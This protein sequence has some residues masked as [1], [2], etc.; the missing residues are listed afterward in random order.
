MRAFTFGAMLA[1]CAGFAELIAAQ[2]V[3]PPSAATASPTPS[4]SSP[5]KFIELNDPTGISAASNTGD[6][7]KLG[8]I[9]STSS[10]GPDVIAK[11]LRQRSLYQLDLS[12]ETVKTCADAAKTRISSAGVQ[13]TFILAG[14]QLL[15][16]D[17]AGWAKAMQQN[18]TL[19]YPTYLNEVAKVLHQDSSTFRINEFETSPDYQPFLNV[20]PVSV[21]RKEKT[22]D[23][24]LK[25]EPALKDGNGNVYTIAVSMNDQLVQMVF[26]TGNSHV[27]LGADDAKRLHI[28]QIYPHW[29]QLPDGNYASL[30]IVKQLDMGG[31]TVSNMPVAIS[32]KPLH[33]HPMLGLSAIQYLDAFQIEGSTLHSHADGFSDCSSPMDMAT[34]INGI[35]QVFVV[36]GTEDSQPFPFVVSTGIPGA[37]SRS[38]YGE[39]DGSV[40]AKPYSAY[41]SLGN[42]YAW[43]SPDHAKMQIGSGPER[44]QPYDVIYHA[45]H[46]RFRYY[47]GADY[48]ALH[49]L[50]M[51]FKRGVMCLK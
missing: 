20:P 32:D 47:V 4:S 38:H 14:N 10:N 5:R 31:V 30:G 35:D 22:F 17:I 23:I 21:S 29:L 12:S 28:D 46:T 9:A 33:W 51:D 50:T 7:D 39:P 42:E 36:R 44:D 1:A 49:P 34:H 27:M 26:D 43:Y 48:I 25:L 2:T 37:I 16:N 45:G 3:N 8:Y 41:S 40:A 24:P 6:Q 11:A 19:A 18:K 15:Q 13:C